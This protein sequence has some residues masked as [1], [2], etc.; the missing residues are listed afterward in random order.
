[1]SRYAL[2]CL[3]LGVLAWGQAGNSN[4]A[5]TMQKSGMPNTAAGETA[6]AN[7]PAATESRT[8]VDV[9]PATPVITINGLC[10]NPHASKSAAT[11]CKTVIT[12]AQF[13]KLIDA[14]QPTMAASVRRQF[15][16]N[17]ARALVMSE[18]AERLGLDK[19][20]AFQEH[21]RLA[22]IQVLSGELNKVIQE[23]AKQISDKDVED[24]YRSNQSKFEQVEMERIYIPKTPQQ[25]PSDAKLS[26]A[27]REKRTQASV[28]A[29]KALADKLHE[30]AVAGEDF[31][32]LQADAY[33]VAGIKSTAANVSLGKVMRSRL[34]PNQVF[35]MDLNPGEISKVIDDQNG[36]FVYKVKSKSTLKLEESSEG[37]KGTLRAQRME[38]EMKDIQESATPALNESYFA[39]P[40]AT[41]KPGET[42]KPSSK[43]QD[44]DDD[45]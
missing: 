43:P 8:A 13:E 7:K 14:V 32:K 17:Y 41:P 42:G 45:D 40:Q 37:I 30:R 39:S 33:Q 34:P 38:E 36:Y 44:D 24:Y 18:K 21:M 20:P 22:R 11:D 35:V 3:L 19:D 16:T 4:S 15:A 23:K 5:P 31:T 27:E 25:E 9:P 2:V 28:E 1:M 12:R 29:M 10:E 6:P 26:M